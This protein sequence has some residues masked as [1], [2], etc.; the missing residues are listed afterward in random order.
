MTTYGACLS[1]A[2]ENSPE[3]MEPY[4]SADRIAKPDVRLPDNPIRMV[5]VSTT[6]SAAEFSAVQ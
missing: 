1:T 5:S 3:A 2:P 6:L 4:R